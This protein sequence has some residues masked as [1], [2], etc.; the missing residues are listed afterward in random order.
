MLNFRWL[1]AC[2]TGRR[3]LRYR[4]KGIVAAKRTAAQT[5][6]VVRKPYLPRRYC[7]SSGIMMP[8]IPV[9]ACRG[10]SRQRA[11]S[12]FTCEKMGCDRSL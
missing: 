7:S 12:M 10:V 6:R 8:P 9:P 3:G 4:V 11:A 2:E 1:V 5:R